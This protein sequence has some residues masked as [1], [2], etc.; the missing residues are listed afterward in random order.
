[1]HYP[2]MV[3]VGSYIL[4]GQESSVI[5][6]LYKN[7]ISKSTNTHQNWDWE[8]VCAIISALLLF[9][10][11]CG[12]WHRVCG[13]FPAYF[14]MLHFISEALSQCELLESESVVHLMSFEHDEN[15][16]NLVCKV[17]CVH[18]RVCVWSDVKLLLIYSDPRV[19]DINKT[20]RLK[21]EK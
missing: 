15:Q 5:L 4:S 18:V 2:L 9:H 1:M 10:L 21:K 6:V 3:V 20:K 14:N 17:I 7:C 13:S 12:I 11:A 16:G 8:N 19:N